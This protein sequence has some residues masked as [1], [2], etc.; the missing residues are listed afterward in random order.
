MHVYACACICVHMWL[1]VHVCLYVSLH[2]R[3]Q[4]V[5]D[6]CMTTGKQTQ[7][8]FTQMDLEYAF[9]QVLLH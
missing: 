9:L 1:S 2:L 4:T 5:E 8:C 3:H 7:V 6:F